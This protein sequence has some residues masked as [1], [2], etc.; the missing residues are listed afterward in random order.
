M[1]ADQPSTSSC[2]K[3]TNFNPFTYKEPPKIPKKMKG[4]QKN[5][6]TLRERYMGGIERTPEPEISR[7]SLPLTNGRRSVLNQIATSNMTPVPVNSR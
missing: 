2:E 5:Y 3:I 7:S 1:F 4:S 6:E